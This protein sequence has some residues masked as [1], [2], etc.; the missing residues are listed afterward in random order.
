[1]DTT[2]NENIKLMKNSILYLLL[3]SFV[4]VGCV[5]EKKEADAP[6][7]EV[8]ALEGTWRLVKYINHEEGET[9]WSEYGEE[10][11]YEKHITPTHFTW[12]K[13]DK[14]KDNLE[15]IGG[16]TY[17]FNGKVYTEDIKFFLPPGSSELGQAIP[18]EVKFEEGKWYHLGY[19]KVYEFDAELGEMV[20]TD[21]TRIEEIWEKVENGDQ[22]KAIMGT[23]QLKSYREEQ[24][25]TRSEYPSFVRYMKSITPT[26][27]IWVKYNGEGDEV[28]AAGSGRYKYNNGSYEENI[29]MIYPPGANQV[30]TTPFFLAEFN[31]GD[32]IHKGYVL[33][34]DPD[35]PSITADSVFIDEVWHK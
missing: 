30:G 15:G 20:M 24:D 21:S 13:Y 31:D 26:H 27:F 7:Y 8:D 33:K 18:F 9:E 3:I 23:W 29:E 11:I 5:G 34:A 25:S 32:W 4:M 10:I 1:M 22:E 16:G 2:K 6:I 28:M 14:S 12:V 35:N 19:A 17:A